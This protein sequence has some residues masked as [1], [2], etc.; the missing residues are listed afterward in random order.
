[1]LGWLDYYLEEDRMEREAEET[2]GYG[3]SISAQYLEFFGQVL[4]EKTKKFL[5]NVTVLDRN[6]LKQLNDKKIGLSVDG[7][8]C[9]S[10]D[11]PALL[12][13]LFFKLVH[14]F[15][16]PSLR[17]SIGDEATFRYL[18]DYKGHIIEV[19]DNKGSIIFAHMTPY[20]IEQEDV[21]PQEDA[22][23]ILEEFVENLL[24]MVMDVTPL[25]YGGARIFL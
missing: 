10:F 18:F 6:F 2:P 21:P 14:I 11:W 25:H 12:P 20:S 17:V 8:P 9:I 4:R 5:E 22:N 3:T 24:Q 15:G 1:M 13:R 7:D 19:S 23:E 16:Y